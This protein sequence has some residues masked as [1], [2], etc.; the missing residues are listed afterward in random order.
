MPNYVTNLIG[1]EGFASCYSHLMLV[2]EARLILF[3]VLIDDR[4]WS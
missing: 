1:I 2:M 3:L 4:L